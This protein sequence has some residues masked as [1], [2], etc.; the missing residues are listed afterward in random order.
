MSASNFSLGITPAS[1]SFVALT[2]TMT[3]MTCLLLGVWMGPGD[4]SRSTGPEP[5]FYHDDERASHGSTRSVGIP[6]RLRVAISPSARGNAEAALVRMGLAT[7][8]GAGF[9]AANERCA[10]TG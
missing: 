8:R 7:H 4:R 10:A 5:C 2:I 3:R 9:V 6:G 1:L